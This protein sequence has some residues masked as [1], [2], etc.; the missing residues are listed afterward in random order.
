MTIITSLKSQQ[1]YR[2]KG[3]GIGSFRRYFKLPFIQYGIKIPVCLPFGDC[4]TQHENFYAFFCAVIMNRKERDRYRYYTKRKPAKNWGSLW[5]RAD[6]PPAALCPT[7]FS[8]FG[9]INI[10]AHCEPADETLDFDA[11]CGLT[12]DDNRKAN[13]G[14]YKGMTVAL[15]YGDF[16]IGAYNKLDVLNVDYQ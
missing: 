9:L 7:Y 1:R 12:Y 6:E 5:S 10:V 8:L 14:K 3:K 15:D 16:R 11:T 4:G 2:P 13:Y